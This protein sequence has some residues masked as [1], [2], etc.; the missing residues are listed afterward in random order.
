M[1]VNLYCGR[2]RSGKSYG[3]VENVIIP[4]LAAGRDVYTNLPLIIDAIELHYPQA[5]GHIHQFTNDHVTPQFLMDIPGG[6]LVVI[7]ECWRFWPS[8]LKATN[9]D[10]R[11]KE[12]FA[13]HG[14][15]VG[16][17]GLTQ[18]IVLITQAP[19]QIAKVIKDLVDQTTVT[20]KLNAVGKDNSYSVKIY[21]ACIPSLERPGTPIISGTGSYKPEIYQFYK[22]HTKSETGLAG[23]E[24]RPDNRGTVWN[25]WYIRYVL[26]PVAIGAIF[27]A[28][29]I[30]QFFAHPKQ[31]TPPATQAQPAQN[32]TA[33]PQPPQIQ[34]IAP[35][36]PANQPKPSK[37]Y[38]IAGTRFNGGY[39]YVYLEDSESRH[40]VT[41][42]P[43]KCTF[44]DLNGPECVFDSEIVTNRTG[45]Q[46]IDDDATPGDLN[47]LVP[48][49]GNKS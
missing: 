4:A 47:N 31:A 41:L 35:Q 33:A 3:V 45:N 29:Y 37:R 19:S 38:R 27:G 1:A 5:Q 2:P 39:L 23:V 11:T 9:L 26:P 20:T 30:Y 10:T 15:K 13:E 28:V 42:K 43:D 49:F 22:S 46:A 6:A 17:S 36:L 12:F 44:D 7:D 18:E 14:H 34:P 21:P 24:L 48:T 25:N 8:G 40:L 32:P 16:Q